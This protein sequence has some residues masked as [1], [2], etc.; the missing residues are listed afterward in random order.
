MH[1]LATLLVIQLLGVLA[2]VCIVV[3]NRREYAYSSG[4][5]PT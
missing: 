3:T 2:R 5:P 4:M 1:T